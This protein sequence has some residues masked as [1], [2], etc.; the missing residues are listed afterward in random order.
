M[1]LAFCA[2]T[3]AMAAMKVWQRCL[4]ESQGGGGGRKWQDGMGNGT[5]QD[6]K[7]GEKKKNAVSRFSPKFPVC[8]PNHQSKPFFLSFWPDSYIYLSILGPEWKINPV[9][10]HFLAIGWGWNRKNK[11]FLHEKR[12]GKCLGSKTYIIGSLAWDG[13]ETGRDCPNGKRDG[14]G[15]GFWKGEH[16]WSVTR[17]GVFGAENRMGGFSTSEND[18]FSQKGAFLGKKVES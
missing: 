15:N 4:R 13:R 5:K 6:G 12:D 11:R 2:W 14:T 9:F 3:M 18:R 10:H 17:L 16:L 7:A 8:S 1:F